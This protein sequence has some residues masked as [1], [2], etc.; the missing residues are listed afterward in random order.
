MEFRKLVLNENQQPR[1]QDI[2]YFE[3]DIYRVLHERSNVAAFSVEHQQFPERNKNFIR[4][5]SS[6]RKTKIS[7]KEPRHFIV[8]KCC[9]ED[10][11]RKKQHRC[12][13]H[14]VPDISR[15]II[16]RLLHMHFW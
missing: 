14:G 15:K 3:N 7:D 6:Q 16:S 10:I 12:F 2:F 4:K 1:I 8:S 13:F 5:V 9:A 11:P